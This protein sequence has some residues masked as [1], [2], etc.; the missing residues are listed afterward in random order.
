MPILDN[1]WELEI[2]KKFLGVYRVF[3]FPPVVAPFLPWSRRLRTRKK[4]NLSLW[5][6]L[7][8]IFFV[9]LNSSPGVYQHP[10][11]PGLKDHRPHLESN[12]E[13]WQHWLTTDICYLPGKRVLV[14]LFLPML[15]VLFAF[16]TFFLTYFTTMCMYG[17][18][19]VD[20]YHIQTFVWSLNLNLQFWKILS[21]LK[22]ILPPFFSLIRYILDHF[23]LPYMPLTSCISFPLLL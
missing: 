22:N 13:Y 7:P 6:Q 11:I 12:F 3:A 9:L 14:V 16:K 15:E 4:G 23:P 17:C 18:G 1:L 20:M 19:L 10:G 21:H 2:C 8:S 5:N